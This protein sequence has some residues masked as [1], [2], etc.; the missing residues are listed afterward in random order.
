MTK[1]KETRIKGLGVSPG[2]GFGVAHVYDTGEVP[3]RATR[4]AVRKVEAEKAR[5]HAAVARTQK[6]I[7]VLRDK[8]AKTPGAAQE[9]LVL[10]FE[11]HLQMLTDS[12]LVRGAERRISEERVN[13]EAAVQ[14]EVAEIAEAFGAMNDSYFAAR[15]DDIREVGNR[16]LRNLVRT[17]IK[18]LSGLPK[19]SIVVTSELTPADT[20]LLRPQRI[21]GIATVLGGVQGHTAIMARALEI[22]AVLGA[23]GLLEG[24]G[25]GD[26]LIVDGESGT[27]VVNP[28]A[29]T[30][31]RYRARHEELQR[32]KRV[33]S[34]LRRLPSTTRNGVDIALRANVE[35]P[36]EMNLVRQ[37]AA[38]GIG[39]LRTEFLFMNRE[40]LPDEDE[41]FE[42]L[43]GIVEGMN[44]GVTTIRTVDAGGE[45]AAPALTGEFGDSAASALGLRG[46]RLSFKR[47]EVFETQLRA[48]LR[49]SAFGPV[50]IL[51]PMVTTVS[52]VRRARKCLAR[53]V[54]QVKRRGL[55]MAPEIPP[56]G[57]MIEVPAAALT[58]D[59]LARVSDFLSIGSNDLTMYTLATD[60]RD[61]NVAA[62]FDTLH[63]AVLRLIH[64]AVSSGFKAGIPVCLCGEVAGDPD[65]SALWLGMGLREL[66]MAATKVPRVK[67]R[68]RGLDLAAA[69]Q[70]ARLIMDQTD[71]AR[72]ATLLEDFN[73]LA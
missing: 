22:P 21:A 5:F 61:E 19:G 13:A 41:Q 39:L 49:A 73:A 4:V 52:E 71:S 1:D 65:Y 9:E 18:P 47:P 28:S 6:Q 8:A 55:A 26:S 35:L 12:R 23:P 29:D 31:A 46:I 25:A 62:Y 67:R 30:L 27:V 48:I 17:P 10:L 60:R 54:R 64:S 14:R 32:E 51:L 50:R 15:V 2:I 66:S 38:D 43:R 16:L 34:R 59:A 45:K 63:P 68:I 33:L 58:A 37:V 20:A 36:L 56:L 57:A 42:I 11:A 53:A 44:G 72:I 24:V 7:A 3:V 70:R 69:E 40:D